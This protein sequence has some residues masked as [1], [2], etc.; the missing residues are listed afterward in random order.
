MPAT[1]I[2]GLFQSLSMVYAAADTV[3][4]GGP[5]YCV[6]PNNTLSTVTINSC[7]FVG[8]GAASYSVAAGQLPVTLNPGQSAI[9]Q[10]N[11]SMGS[12]SQP[13]QGTFATNTSYSPVITLSVGNGGG[14]VGVFP[15]G[16]GLSFPTTKVGLSSNFV[17][18][19]IVNPH[20]VAITVS[21]LALTTGTDFFITSAPALPL[22]LPAGASSAL[23]GIQFTPT[24]TGS[25]NDIL[26]ATSNASGVGPG[27]P[28][29]VP[30]IGMGTT[31]ASAFNLTGATT[32]SLFAFNGALVGPIIL[33]ANPNS[34][35]CEE[36]GKFIKLHDFAQPNIEKTLMRIRGHYEDLG[37]AV[38]TFTAKA[39]RLG[40]PDE[41]IQ[42][43]VNIGTVFAD[44][45]IRE[46]TSEPTPVSGE[47]IQLTCSRAL[48]SGPASLI[49]YVP[50]FESE[51]EVIGGT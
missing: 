51:G 21:N 27:G 45:W 46:F 11:L 2:N 39:R 18:M 20:S 36:A 16:L 35:N 44:G 26:T 41:T 12:G 32:G 33:I 10:I 50:Q 17:N 22:T 31:L 8:T 42:V 30:L 23:F 1:V 7:S 25:R 47:L 48:N 24:V 6:I 19:V 14:L 38:I 43:N 4:Q 15:G 37:P 40:K 49:D 9:I 5:G 28:F 34:L 3:G 29:A 13:A